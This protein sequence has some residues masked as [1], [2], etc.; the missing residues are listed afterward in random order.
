MI[1]GKVIDQFF[2]SHKDPCFEGQ[3]LLLI[4]PLALDGKPKG[5]QIL[6]ID[7]VESGVGDRV[8]CAIDGWASMTVLGEFFTPVYAAVLGIVDQ[9]D[10][11]DTEKC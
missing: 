10:L 5:E 3:K 6:A 8:L 9:V 2:S 1:I 11:F 7:G 4:Q